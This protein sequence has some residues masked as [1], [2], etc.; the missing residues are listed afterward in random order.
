MPPG[1][2]R[3]RGGRC[4]TR[5]SIPNAD[6]LAVIAPPQREQA[7]EWRCRAMAAFRAER[8]I[9]S[10]AAV[11]RGVRA[12]GARSASHAPPR[13][14]ASFFRGVAQNRARRG[15]P[16]AGHDG[17]DAPTDFLTD[18]STLA[19][20]RRASAATA[21]ARPRRP[22]R[23]EDRDSRAP[24]P[25]RATRT[26]TPTTR[27]TSWRRRRRRPR[28]AIP[29]RS[30]VRRRNRRRR[31]A[32]GGGAAARLC[33]CF[34]RGWRPRIKTRA[35]IRWRSSR[36]TGGPRGPARPED[37]GARV[38]VLITLS[39]LH[40]AL[41]AKH[42]AGGAA[43]PLCSTTRSRDQL[44]LRAVFGG[45]RQPRLEDVAPR[46]RSARASAGP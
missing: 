16:R 20:A 14:R 2:G 10:P 39:M 19:E 34:S 22:P 42:A 29:R 35:Q 4:S 9:L 5:A 30:V 41:E 23:P 21:A 45:G 28:R 3:R 31:M 27:L 38:G 11:R 6:D 36:G 1:L 7:D 40:P 12:P 17:S 26:S 33:W 32:A 24:R 18:A 8:L 25:R 15:T 43:P 44:D 37:P 13:A 46:P